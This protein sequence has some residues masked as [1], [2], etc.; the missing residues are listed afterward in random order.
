MPS[1]GCYALRVH[2]YT[3][4]GSLLLVHCQIICECIFTFVL[5]NLPAFEIVA[6]FTIYSDVE[7]SLVL[8]IIRGEKKLSF[9][10]LFKRMN[11]SVCIWRHLALSGKTN[12]MLIKS[13]YQKS[14]LE[15]ECHSRAR[16]EFHLRFSCLAGLRSNEITITHE[17]KPSH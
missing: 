11:C 5:I 8:G 7:F 1:K 13:I 6:S 4:Q 10:H 16:F 9:V 17:L 3:T 2:N 12:W 14:Q 15:V